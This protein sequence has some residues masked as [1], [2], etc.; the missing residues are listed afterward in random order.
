MTR[1]SAWDFVFATIWKYSE[2]LIRFNT[3][4]KRINSLVCVYIKIILW[5]TLEI[6]LCITFGI[7]RAMYSGFISGNKKLK[8]KNA[9]IWTYKIRYKLER[10]VWHQL[11]K[12]NQVDTYRSLFQF[13]LTYLKN[14]FIFWE[15]ILFMILKHKRNTQNKLNCL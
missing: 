14:Y 8:T 5:Y 12:K 11:N 3:K 6:A 9:V 7:V 2:Y 10:T 1:I 4:F 13:K 15:R